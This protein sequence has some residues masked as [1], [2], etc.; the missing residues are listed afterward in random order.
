M[1][2]F[3]FTIQ[4]KDKGGNYVPC[5]G[6]CKDVELCLLRTGLSQCACVSGDTAFKRKSISISEG[7][8]RLLR[9]ANESNRFSERENVEVM[10]AMAADVETPEEK[11]K[12]NDEEDLERSR[13]KQMLGWYHSE[14]M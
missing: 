3:K 10:H 4:V 14:Y 11:G 9:S 1:K 8:K 2:S 13:V 12:E 7:K 6:T 5:E